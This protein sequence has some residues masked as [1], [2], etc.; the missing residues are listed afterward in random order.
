M[1]TTLEVDFR[2]PQRVLL[3]PQCHVCLGRFELTPGVLD[4]FLSRGTRLLC[5]ES[6]L[7]QALRALQGHFM[8]TKFALQFREFRLAASCSVWTSRMARRSLMVR[9]ISCS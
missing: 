6:F 9:A 1:G 8:T 7:D 5:G 3:L 4:L 2:L